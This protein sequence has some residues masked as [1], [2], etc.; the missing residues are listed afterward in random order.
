MIPV[1]FSYLLKLNIGLVLVYLFYRLVLQNLTFYNWNRFYL[2]SF[3]VLS[4]L[5]PLVDISA[6]WEGARDT[7]LPA[8]TRYI[9]P[10][11]ALTTTSMVVP[12]TANEGFTLWDWLLLVMLSGN[13]IL[14]VK[15]VVQFFSFMR[16]KRK[17][18]LISNQRI[19]I[20]QIDADI[21]PF[22]FGRSIF[23]N[24]ANY[25]EHNRQEIIKHELVH[26]QQGHTADIIL[27]ELVSILNWYNPFTW[28][29]RQ[30][31]RQNLEFIADNQVLQSG[32]DK[33]TY[34]YLLLQVNGLP[35]FP[36]ANQF[37][38]SP[39]KKRIIMMNKMPNA[40]PHLIKFLLLLPLVA[41]LL[42]A[43][44]GKEKNTGLENNFIGVNKFITENQ[45]ISLQQSEPKVLMGWR[46]EGNNKLQLLFQDGSQ[47]P[48]DLNTE[49]GKKRFSVA[50]LFVGD[51][52]TPDNTE[53]NW[54]E[55]FKIF[56]N[57]NPQVAQIKWRYD[58]EQLKKNDFPYIADRLYLTLKSGAEEVYSIESKADLTKVENKFGRLPML[59]PPIPI[60]EIPE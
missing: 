40:R 44:R 14:L 51:A 41:V 9:Y 2:L 58:R 24:P 7:P 13:G 16:R 32:I 19:K 26:V 17:A 23:L 45:I 29:L 48:C 52:Y 37:N 38:F 15:T 46:D 11:E 8:M 27:M 21:L 4:F 5:I 33:K 22:S 57:Q 18:R 60:W 30:Q 55:D 42:V 25:S 56:L 59:S 3:I 43:F 47:E 50:Q 49:A 20:Y 53:R 31:L 28:L 6:L 39:L 10:V 36:L 54:P 34:Q 12:K 1:F 35:A